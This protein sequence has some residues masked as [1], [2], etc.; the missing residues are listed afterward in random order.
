[1]E[2]ELRR[3]EW[4]ANINLKFNSTAKSENGEIIFLDIC[5]Y[6]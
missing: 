2:M 5:L 1:M 4:A 3:E 6:K